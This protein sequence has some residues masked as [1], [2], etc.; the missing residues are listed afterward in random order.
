MAFSLLDNLI[1]ACLPM[2]DHVSEDLEEIEKH[3]FEGKEREMLH[4]IA[5]IKRDLIDFRR[6][7]KPQ[8]S[9]LELFDKKAQRIY[10]MEIKRLSQEVIGSNIRVW[11]VLENHREL[12][13][14][15]EQTNNSL[16]SHKLSDIMKILTIVSFI[17]FPL[18]VV[19]GFFGMNVYDSLPIVKSNPNAWWIILA[20][21]L[22]SAITMFIYFKIKKWL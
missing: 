7:I 16:L 6:A 22:V 12:I 19:T 14:S 3:V 21:M 15:I 5:R 8:R 2:L 1:D 13:T 20:M 11:N 10:G 9:V 4:E 18:S 17:T